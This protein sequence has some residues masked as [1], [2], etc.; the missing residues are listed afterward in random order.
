L[1]PQE[2]NGL[3]VRY[4]KY[5]QLNISK[6][7]LGFFS[8]LLTGFPEQVIYA[9]DVVDDLGIFDAKKRSHEIQE[10]SSNKAKLILDRYTLNADVLEF[11]YLLSKFEFISYELIFS[12]VD[13]PTH[14]S[15]L[16]ELLSTAVCERLG[17]SGEYIRVNEVI[18]D[19]ISRGRF[20]IPTKY[21]PAISSH[22]E[23]YIRQYKDDSEDLA[24]YLFSVQEAVIAGKS[25]PD[26]ILI[27]SIIIK[28]IKKLYDED[29]NYK[30][31][32]KL[33]NRV[34][35]QEKTI[36]SN[37]VKHVRYIKCQCLARLADRDFF[38][39]VQHIEE[40]DKSFLFG[41]YYRI[42]GEYERAKKSF[43][44]VLREKSNDVRAIGELVRVFI[45]TEEYDQAFEMAKVN[46]QARPGNPINLN[47]YFTCLI[48]KE[49]TT[50]NRDELEKVLKTLSLDTSERA[51][52]MSLS[53]K[54]RL[55]AL[56][57]NDLAEAFNEIEEAINTF[58][59]NHYPLLTKA[60]LAVH[61]RNISKLSESLTSLEPKI[62][63]RSNSYRSFLRYKAFLIAL[64]GRALEAKQF[65]KKELSG[66][67][68]RAMERL[69]HRIE[70]LSKPL[71]IA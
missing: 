1:H 30:D 14:A 61:S 31:A 51:Q 53:A 64:N 34:L 49:K 46:Y 15:I 70:E 6:E 7:D 44:R 11:I 69:N 47:N 68:P 35:Q 17:S 32:L 23:E 8:D 41:F 36:H 48:H 45:Q 13:E 67:G 28:T 57:D 54:A 60:D 2:R 20:G 5:R 63:R 62:S 29:R 37:S 22:V 4:A 65:A 55:Y 50:E 56:Y 40:P 38:G 39:E 71:T 43:F 9:V 3:L 66:I 58:P 26:S 42:V 52:E 19:Y 16:N 24:D 27:P 18:R 33:C 21:K 59:E 25:V 10:Y 12:I